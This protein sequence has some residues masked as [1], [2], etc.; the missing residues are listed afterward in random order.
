MAMG[1]KK[2]LILVFVCLASSCRSVSL[3]ASDTTK[4]EQLEKYYRLSTN[5]NVVGDKQK[6]FDYFPSTFSEFNLLYGYDSKTSKPQV[7]YNEASDH[8]RGLLCQLDENEIKG[9]YDKLISL[10]YGSEWEAD[11]VN[12]LQ[13]CIQKRFR[14]NSD[15]FATA[16]AAKNQGQM[17]QFFAFYFSGPPDHP[18]KKFPAEIDG[19]KSKYP[20]VHKVALDVFNN[21]PKD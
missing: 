9:Y 2:I 14:E 17:S 6:F 18:I 1:I 19:L 4:A 7:L 8:I 5:T 12:Y 13:N 10:T 3:P 21:L 20:K 11:A 16:L 15:S